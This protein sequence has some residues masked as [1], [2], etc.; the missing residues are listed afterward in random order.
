M[1]R[2]IVVQEFEVALVYGDY[3]VPALEGAVV[4][5]QVRETAVVL[6]VEIEHAFPGR[7]VRVLHIVHAPAT[8]RTSDSD[9]VLHRRSQ[10]LM[11]AW[12]ASIED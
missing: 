3:V 8:R 9:R 11:V 2:T 6:R 10:R 1:A 12:S 5:S 7:Q 4:A